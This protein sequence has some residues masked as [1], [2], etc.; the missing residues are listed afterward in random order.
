MESTDNCDK[1]KL[2]LPKI[3]NRVSDEYRVIKMIGEGTFGTVVK[4]QHRQS[5][6][7][8]AIKLIEGITKNQ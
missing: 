1:T 7:L 8:V 6:D 3:W 4:A 2:T 5:G